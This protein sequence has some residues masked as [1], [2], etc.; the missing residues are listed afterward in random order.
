MY[1][2]AARAIWGAIRRPRRDNAITGPANTTII[3]PKSHYGRCID[4]G[5]HL[6]RSSSTWEERCRGGAN[7]AASRAGALLAGWF[8][9]L[10]Y[11]LIQV[12]SVLGRGV[13]LNCWVGVT[14]RTSETYGSKADLVTSWNVQIWRDLPW[15]VQ[16]WRDLLWEGQV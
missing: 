2:R 11:W 1:S 10:L 16:V 5:R 14:E 12:S 13:R 6:S 9:V 15:D 7:V 3:G 8:P 4:A